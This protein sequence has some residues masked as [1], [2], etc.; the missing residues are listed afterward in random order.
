MSPRCLTPPPGQPEAGLRPCCYFPGIIKPLRHRTTARCWT[1]PVPPTHSPTRPTSRP[2]SLV[3]PS[4]EQ[5]KRLWTRPPSCSTSTPPPTAPRRNHAR[6]CREAMRPSRA[7][8]RRHDLLPPGPAEEPREI[9]RSSA[10]FTQWSA[11]ELGRRASRRA[12]TSLERTALFR[13]G[14]SQPF[15]WP[16]SC[17]FAFLAA[18]GGRRMLL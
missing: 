15:F 1:H 2:R 7:A 12:L 3:E 10:L 18:P 9:T 16:S 17:A 4:I 11:S 6:V 14:L 5:L 13:A 8:R